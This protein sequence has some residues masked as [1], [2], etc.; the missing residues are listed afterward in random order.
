M[1][2][3]T[4]RKLLSAAALVALAGGMVLTPKASARTLLWS[5]EFS[6]T[7]V[8]TKNW[9]IYDN[10]ADGSDSWF[11]ARNLTVSGGTL[12]IANKEESYNGRHWSGG[13]LE[14][15]A[16]HPQYCYLEARVRITPANCYDWST[17][18]TIGWKNN[19]SVWPPEFDICEFQGGPNKS[20]GQ[21][22]HWTSSNYDTKSTGKDESQWHTYGV[23]WTATSSPQFYV[24]GAKSFKS[25][26]TPSVAA[27]AAKM[28]LSSSP[29][30][31][32][33]F[34][35]CTLGVMEVD[36]VRVYDTP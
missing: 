5:D 6:G 8:N 34:S 30:S 25:G 20:P 4:L 14:C 36:Y 16:N 15:I 27:M 24:D 1:K 21:S 12:K 3:L 26:G 2:K 32:N 29:N 19:A 10:K 33:R 7:S 23:Y 18:W 31:M 9:S 11:L 13:G 22:Y 35:G 17:W 28:K